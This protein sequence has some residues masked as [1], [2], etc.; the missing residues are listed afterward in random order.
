[1]N[2]GAMTRY[3]LRVYREATYYPDKQLHSH[4][5]GRLERRAKQLEREGYRVKLLAMTTDGPSTPASLSLP[6]YD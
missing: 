4:S 6:R 3:L 2:G 5:L 1:M